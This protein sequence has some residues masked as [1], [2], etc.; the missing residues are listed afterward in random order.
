MS[1]ILPPELGERIVGLIM[2][3]RRLTLFLVALLTLGAAAAG[4]RVGVDNA[5]EVWFLDD[6]PSLLAYH[7]FQQRFG[8]DEVVVIAFEP[9]GGVYSAE[10]L[11]LLRRVDIAVAAVDGIER[12]SS[13]ASVSTADAAG[14]G[15]DVRPG[16]PDGPLDA[17]SATAVQRRVEA[18]ALLR[19]LVS[20]DGKQ[21]LIL[22]QMQAME[23]IDARRDSILAEVRAV[24]QD[25]AGPQTL[26]FAGIGII[27][28]ALNDLSTRGSV[29]YMAGSTLVIGLLLWRL[30][31][32]WRAVV[33]PMAIV[34]V[35]SVWLMGIYGLAGRDINMVTMV[36]PTLVLVI[37]VSDCVHMLTHVAE[38]DRNLPQWERVRRGVGFVFWPCLFNTLTSAVGFLALVTAPMPVVRDL[39]LFSA[40]GILA[41]FV[42]SVAIC[43]TALGN[44]RFEPAANDNGK[45]QRIVERLATWGADHSSPVLVVAALLALVAAL[46]ITRLEVDTYSI[47]FLKDEHPVRV[48]SDS[49][50]ASYGPYTPLE[51]VVERPAGVRDPALFSAVAVWQARVEAEPDVGWTR[52]AVSAVQHLDGLLRDEPGAGQV[53]DDPA[54]LDQLLLLYESDRDS[55]LDELLTPDGKGLR[56]TVG[57]QMG[58]AKD[59]GEEIARFSALAQ[60]PPDARLVPSG[61]L[62]LY[63]RMMDYIVKSQLSSFA[64]GFV[65]IFAI[66]G[67]LFRSISVAALAV[68]A[69]LLPV[70]L[71]LGFMGVAG[72]P[73]DVATVTISAVVLGLVVDDTIQLFY[74]FRH[75]LNL[76]GDHREA[77]LRS[78]RAV[79]RPMLITAIVLGLGFSVLGFAA[80]KSVA[81]FGLL[82]AAALVFAAFSE[83]LVVPALLVALKPRV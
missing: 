76:T 34:G 47:G 63:V 21:A 19:R 6:D 58:S 79:G 1:Q 57:V 28:A 37:G 43:S 81:W 33:L 41:A 35:G 40:L 27:Y 16:L 51:F 62:P 65:G 67:L 5:V 82:T 32:H 71:V 31:G 38:Q 7:D 73:L 2:R 55:D 14:G 83:L 53:P 4:A 29:A 74:R 72:I 52:S 17:A 78:V 54:A 36:M 61:Y 39:G 13:L 77:T 64:T 60:L 12:V 22:G 56:V 59:F 3:W 11:E 25:A 10:N 46:G 75:E 26:R 44:P 80:V 70:L 8:N 42:A 48:D 9:A 23:G 50:E 20:A 66:I 30:L 18:D 15:L 69:N 45:V 68:P 24:A 49:I